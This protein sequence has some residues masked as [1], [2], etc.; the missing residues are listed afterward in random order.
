VEAVSSFGAVAYFSVVADHNEAVVACNGT[1]GEFYPVGRTTVVCTISRGGL[2]GIPCTV[3]LDVLD[4]AAPIYYL[5]PADVVLDSAAGRSTAAWPEPV[6]YDAVDGENLVL[7]QSHTSGVDTFGIGTTAIT[8]TATDATGNTAQCSFNVVL[9]QTRALQCALVAVSGDY[10]ANIHTGFTA[11]IAGALGLDAAQVTRSG[12][13][14]QVPGQLLI[15]VPLAVQF[16]DPSQRKDA[17][18][19]VN[20]TQDFNQAVGAFGEEEGHS[21]FTTEDIVQ[22]V[23]REITFESSADVDIISGDDSSSVSGDSA[24]S[25]AASE[26]FEELLAAAD[27][28][29]GDPCEAGQY[30]ESLASSYSCLD[31]PL[32]IYPR[33]TLV[34]EPAFV[35]FGEKATDIRL[36]CI[37]ASRIKSVFVGDQK[38][39]F[40]IV[41]NAATGATRRRTTLQDLQFEPY[42]SDEE[43]E[44]IQFT[45]PLINMTAHARLVITIDPLDVGITDTLVYEDWLYYVSEKGEC[46]AE[47][48]YVDESC[49]CRSCP[50]GGRCPGG[51]VVVPAPGFWSEDVIG[52]VLQCKVTAACLGG[53]GAG[54]CEAG[55]HDVACSECASGYFR[56]G[57]LCKPCGASDGDRADMYLRIL[58]ALVVLTL[59]IGVLSVASPKNMLISKEYVLALQQLAVVFESGAQHLPSNLDWLANV[60]TYSGIVNWD[61]DVIKPGCSVPMISFTTLYW[62][63]ITLIVVCMAAAL[64]GTYAYALYKRMTMQQLNDRLNIVMVAFLSLISMRVLTLSLRALKCVDVDGVLV[65]SVEPAVTCFADQHLPVA[66]FSMAAVVVMLLLFPW[67]LLGQLKCYNGLH[68]SKT[69]TTTTSSSSTLKGDAPVAFQPS[70]RHY[71]RKYI[72]RF[73]YLSISPLYISATIAVVNISTEDR[74]ARICA[75]A[76]V[77]GLYAVFVIFSM[78]FKSVRGLVKNTAKSL[79]FLLMSLLLLV[80]MEEEEGGGTTKIIWINIFGV[81]T[82]MILMAA[83]QSFWRLYKKERLARTKVPKQGDE[84]ATCVDGNDLVYE[85]HM[86]PPQ[87]GVCVCVCVS[88]ALIFIVV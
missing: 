12:P 71:A 21:G 81:F 4:R 58:A 74:I 28:C 50:A 47:G 67:Q 69:I 26:F 22:C 8:Y 48:Q 33:D 65:L 56:L 5:C 43:L 20:A 84:D 45:A 55:Y 80:A 18:K 78:P 59:L 9:Q 6:V 25:D 57:D 72:L 73:Y 77:V 76:V 52:P 82:G 35:V 88:W 46:L 53:S 13:T 36:S 63:S 31:S 30:C 19:A 27:Y 34:L 79:I 11:S 54:A 17:D 7:T 23:F 70:I 29:E 83:F 40:T 66:L 64:S 10:D 24:S 14:V 85:I 51:G 62:L 49:R 61:I 86:P 75:P 38:V 3:T 68:T 37:R 16:Y 41:E 32:P 42:S 44:S 15:V 1:S 39:A 60:L 2:A 87:T